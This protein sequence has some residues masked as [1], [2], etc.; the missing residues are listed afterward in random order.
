[1]RRGRKAG[2][3]ST[4]FITGDQAISSDE[5]EQVTRNYSP[6]VQEQAEETPEQIDRS[7]I[8]DTERQ[9]LDA[10]SESTFQSVFEDGQQAYNERAEAYVVPGEWVSPVVKQRRK[11]AMLLPPFGAIQDLNERL[12]VFTK[13][14]GMPEHVATLAQQ[15]RLAIGAAT[16]AHE[17][18]RHEDNRRYA[19]ST[20]AKDAVVQEIAKATVA[21]GAFED[22]A[23]DSASEWFEGLVSNLD[24][25]RDDALKA[26]KAAE[27]AYAAFRS[28]VSTANT[29]AIETERWDKAWHSSTVR[30]HDLNV[31]ISSIRDAIGFLSGD[32]DYASGAFLTAEYDGIP[33]HTLDRLKRG[34]EVSGGGSYAQQLYLRAVK[35]EDMDA[36]LA[37]ERKHLIDFLNSAPIAPDETPLSEKF[38]GGRRG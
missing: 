27:K 12:S 9:R 33:P 2:N 19:V 5:A 15:A 35:P 37:I 18:A 32:N 14:D 7:P 25:Q 24:K 31:P 1:M 21:V 36:R 20:A 38:G 13:Y 34:A 23:R 30:E 4:S 26:L 11:Q 22:A 6:S 10:A 29:L 8:S 28:T 17:S 3:V 16:E